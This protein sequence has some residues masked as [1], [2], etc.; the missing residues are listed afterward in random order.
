MKRIAPILPILL[1]AL[2]F[3]SCVNNTSHNY[4]VRYGISAGYNRGEGSSNNGIYFTIRDEYNNETYCTLEPRRGVS[5]LVGPVYKG[6][7]AEINISRSTDVPVEETYIEVCCG[8]EPW[9]RKAY[10]QGSISYTIDF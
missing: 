4:Y 2:I 7:T 1:I 5:Y 3:S 9:V 8:S 6:F 10:G